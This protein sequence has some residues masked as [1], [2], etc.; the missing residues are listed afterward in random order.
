MSPY[1]FVLVM[2][3]WNTLLRYRVHNASDF[4]HN[5]KCKDLNILNI[6]FA[7]DV[8]LFCKAHLPSTQLFKDTLCEFSVL[9][10]LTVNPAK[11]QII[12]SHAAQQDK[13]QMLDLL[14]FQEGFLPVKYLGVLLSASRLTIAD[15][16]PLINNLESR[17]EGWNQLNLSFAGRTLLIKS[18][19]CTLHAYWASDQLVEDAK[20]AWELVCKTKEEG[21]LGI[22]S[23]TVMNQA[24]ILK[25]LWKL[26]QMDRSSIWVDWI[27]QYRLRNAIIWS[28]TGATGS[29]GWKK[30]L[31]LR[32]ILKSGL[33]YKV[34]NGDSFKLWKDIWHEHGPLC[35]SYPRGPTTTDPDISNIVAILPPICPNEPN[36]ITWRISSGKFTVQSAISLIQPPAP[37]V[38]W[39]VLLQ[40]RYII[41]KHCFIIWL[42]ILEKLSTTDKPWITHEV[43]G[44]VL[45][46]GHFDETHTH[47]FF[48]C[49][50]SKW[51]LAILHSKVRFQWPYLGWQ[52][53]I[54]W[55]SK[56]WQRKHLIHVASRAALAALV[57]HLWTERNNQRINATAT[58]AESLVFQV[59]EDIRMRILSDAFIPNLQTSAL[60]RL[61]K[62]AWPSG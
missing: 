5:W 25:H 45:C 23:I 21:G 8:L 56:R 18:V 34:G 41:A 2:E 48:N 20:V 58:S 44:C 33:I 31:K 35:L 32:P 10:G 51:C 40:G 6:C 16:R 50:Y 57:Y 28:F 1:L 4:Q 24:L 37:L 49:Y 15:C 9:S 47:L 61:W 26:V 60:Y 59:M 54:T 7:D 46:D 53:G 43:D 30:M 55:A 22:R 38:K 11:S 42:A 29:W 52:Q 12:L 39:H 36:S 27:L 17:L 62:I 13:Q 14:G 19:L 3:V